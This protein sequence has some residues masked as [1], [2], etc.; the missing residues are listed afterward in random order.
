MDT[1]ARASVAGSAAIKALSGSR[2]FP[3]C[4]AVLQGVISVPKLSART[5][6]TRVQT[7]QWSSPSQSVTHIAF[8]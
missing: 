1:D 2:A 7:D 8:L 6:G 5:I 4:V 3:L